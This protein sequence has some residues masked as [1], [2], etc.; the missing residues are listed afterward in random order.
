M[1]DSELPPPVQSML[2]T[3]ELGDAGSSAV[4]IRSDEFADEPGHQPTLQQ[5]RIWQILTGA[6]FFEDDG[7]LDNKMLVELCRKNGIVPMSKSGEPR[8][9]NVRQ[10]F[11][12][13]NLIS[14][15]KIVTGKKY[16]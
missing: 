2:K 5:K 9:G 10:H 14:V 15:E 1:K 3:V 12:K 16:D 13:L 7:S 11:E 4:V 8:V 6:V